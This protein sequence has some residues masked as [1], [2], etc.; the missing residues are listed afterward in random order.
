MNKIKQLLKSI[1]AMFM[2]PF[3]SQ[4]DGYG[5]EVKGKIVMGKEHNED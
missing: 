4:K 2:A 1:W 5:T 3:G